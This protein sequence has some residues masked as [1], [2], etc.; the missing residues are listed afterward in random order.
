MRA[1]IFSVIVA[2]MLHSLSTAMAEAPQLRTLAKGSFSGIDEPKQEVIKDRQAWEKFW[3]Q[4]S[5]SAKP[6][7]KPPEVDFA[8]EMAIVVTM[9]KQRKG[10]YAVEIISAKEIEKRLRVTIKTVL[11]KPGGMSIQA[12]TA[13]FHYVAAPRS[14]LKPEFIEEKRPA[15]NPADKVKP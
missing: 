7:E 4:H 2:I 9:G 11:P 1:S 8:K 5:V 6:Q 13:P 15:E 10:G 14:D 3:S 12:L